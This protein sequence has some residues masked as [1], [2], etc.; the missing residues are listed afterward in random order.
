MTA[1]ESREVQRVLR[2]ASAKPDQFVIEAQRE[3]CS[4]SLR[5][6]AR[7]AWRVLEP[8]TPLITGWYFD[9]MADH[10]EAML[11]GEI[12]WLIVNIPPGFGKSTLWSVFLPSYAWLRQPSLRFISGSHSMPLAT[13]D[14]VRT[15]DLILSKWYSG[16]SRGSV[17]LTQ[18][19]KTYYVN[20]VKGHRIAVS[21]GGGMGMRADFGILDDPQT[22]AQAHS[23][24]EAEGAWE[25][26]KGEFIQRLNSTVERPSRLAVIMQ[27]LSKMDLV[28]RLLDHYGARFDILC[29]TQRKVVHVS[30]PEHPSAGVTSTALTRR[31]VALD[32]R[33]ESGDLLCPAKVG[34]ADVHLRQ[35]DAYTFA[36]QDQQAPVD[37]AGEERR[38]HGYTNECRVSFAS[39]FPAGLSLHEVTQAATR[40]GWQFTSGWDHGDSGGREVALLMAIHEDRKLL[41]VLDC[42]ANQKRT[43]PTDDAI[44][45]RRLLDTWGINPRQVVK[46]RGDINGAG[47]AD[48]SGDSI[49]RQIQMATDASGL[50][51]GFPIDP[52][53]KQPGSIELG[54]NLMNTFFYSRG[55]FVDPRA[56]LLDTVLQRWLGEKDGTEHPIDALRYRATPALQG[57][58]KPKVER[59]ARVRMA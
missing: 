30:Q 40:D 26:C 46:S 7:F 9:C 18:V 43:T 14:T 20:S 13:R 4:R 56:A 36:A 50:I 55:L 53:E 3:L 31:G 59:V 29:L 19:L 27:R 33:V 47:K 10:A 24:T 12:P 16:I 45:F 54:L 1:Q 32:P 21:V 11:Q 17:S 5:H 28:S 41:H 44:G 42:Y 35:L 37:R 51:L 52:P 34:E 6:Y 22:N 48:A 49:N 23:A 38:L 2:Y 39:L 8:A 25:W 58:L 57:F 15:R